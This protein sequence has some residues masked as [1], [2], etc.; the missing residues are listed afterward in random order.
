[1]KIF[2]VTH[3]IEEIELFGKLEPNSN[4]DKAK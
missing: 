4:R 3:R 2:V 1:M